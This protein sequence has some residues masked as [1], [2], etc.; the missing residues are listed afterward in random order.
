MIKT[1]PGFTYLKRCECDKVYPGDLDKCSSCGSEWWMPEQIDPIY[2]GYDIETYPNAFT[3][4]IIHIATDT[5]WSFE[6]SEFHD[7]TDEFILMLTSLKNMKAVMVGF[8]NQGFD[9]PVIHDLMTLPH[10]G[11]QGT[12]TKAQAIIDAKGMDRFKHTIWDN[13]TY[14]KQLDLFKINHYDN[15]AK[16][17]SLKALEICM[18]MKNV[19]DLPFPPGT[20]LTRDQVRVLRHYNEHDTFATCLFFVRNLDGIAFRK[21]LSERYGRD[22]TNHNDTKIG[23]DYFIMELEKKGIQCYEHING[24][25]HPRQT[26]RP[27]INLNEVVFPYIK[28]DNPEFTRLLNSIKSKTITETK[29]V[30]K[31]MVAHIHGLEY[32]FGTGGLHASVAGKDIRTSD[33]H[34]LVDVDVASFYPNLAISNQLYPAHL[35]REFC[36]IYLDVYNQ[37]KTYSKGQ[38]EN[39]MLK[40]ALNG[41]Y[42]DSNNPHSVFFDS[43]Y[44]MSIT[45]NG[46]LLLCMLA[47]QLIKIPGLRMVQCNTDGVTFLCPNEYMGHQRQIQKW[48][49]SFT[50][51][52]L[53]EALYERMVILNVNSYMAIKEDGGIKRIKDYC[54]ETAEEN[55]ATRELPYHKDWSALVVPKA[56]QAA[57]VDGVDIETF[58]RS[59]PID[60]DFMLKAKVKR[61]DTLVMRWPEWGGAQVELPNTCRYFASNVGGTL[62]KIAPAKGVPG[63]WKRAN[64]LTDDY[65]NL[66]LGEI[67]SNPP[68]GAQLDSMG[69]PHDE[70]IHTKNKSQHDTVET[71]IKVGWRVTECNDLDQFD[72][73]QVCYEYYIAEAKKLV[74]PLS[75]EF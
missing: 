41:V 74:E 23:K 53:K 75:T 16:S 31:D 21:T 42:G 68:P 61:A 4:V 45:I 69:A 71:G 39:G 58:I 13:K 18:N 30:F 28:F 64:K 15:H 47:D 60:R 43:F 52:E 27:S 50:C 49:E 14:I 56:A 9:Y 3:C 19:K 26:I 66:I 33:T 55:A 11:Y 59:H 40:L 10:I 7:D 54:H 57:L 67:I 29:G 38:V 22:F 8:N 25:R 73:N 48:W 1:T 46:Q 32:V 51:L 65:Y 63:S 20:V 34:Q 44:T 37:R 72:R 6:I 5:R 17:T 12:Y 70:R 24:K 36:D 35:G 62:V 2:Y